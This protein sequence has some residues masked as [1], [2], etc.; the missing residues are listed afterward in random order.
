MFQFLIFLIEKLRRIQ[1]SLSV[2]PYFDLLS[3]VQICMLCMKNT[4]ANNSK[5]NFATCSYSLCDSCEESRILN[6]CIQKIILWKMFRS[7]K[8]FR[9]IHQRN[10]FGVFEISSMTVWPSGLR[11]CLQAPVRKG[12]GSN[13][14]A[15]I[16]KVSKIQIKLCM[17]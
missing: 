10:R 6:G 12:V 14:T 4:T 9:F 5:S 1:L 7:T 15:V 11:R 2:S 17:I 13:P 8:L 16:C 3:I